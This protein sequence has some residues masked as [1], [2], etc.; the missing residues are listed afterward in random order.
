MQSQ[1]GAKRQLCFESEAEE[2]LVEPKRKAL[3]THAGPEPKRR[4]WGEPCQEEA[5]STERASESVLDKLQ[6]AE[7]R[8]T[9]S[10]ILWTER[11]AGAF[12]IAF[13]Q[14]PLATPGAPR[15][16]SATISCPKNDPLPLWKGKKIIRWTRLLGKSESDA[17]AVLLQSILKQYGL[18]C[19]SFV[20]HFAM[21][22]PQPRCRP[23]RHRLRPGELGLWA[24]GK[25]VWTVVMEGL[26]RTG[27]G[28]CCL[29]YV[30]FE[31]IRQ[32]RSRC[33][34]RDQS[35]VA[36]NAKEDVYLAS[37]LVALAQY[38]RTTAVDDGDDT[39]AWTVHLLGLPTPLAEELLFYTATIPKTFLDGLAQPL[40][41]RLRLETGG[42]TVRYSSISLVK[43]RRAA[44]LIW[45]L[46]RQHELC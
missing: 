19:I 24:G 4:Q 34:P 7:T 14:V 21:E 36:R 45:K 33:R 3:C 30:H 28:R 39:Q 43:P 6:R 22:W 26:Y 23:G 37:I 44:R 46:L 27:Q 5:T 17:Q 13:E 41:K 10:P 11:L 2:D 29:A 1:L 32:M 8:A 16:E 25:M 9:V 40:G 42:F 35:A 18:E 20:S 31:N 15:V 38:Q 12:G